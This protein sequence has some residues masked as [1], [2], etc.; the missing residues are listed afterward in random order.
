MSKAKKISLSVLFQFVSII[1]TGLVGILVVPLIIELLG[2][3][4]FGVLEIIISLM[5]LNFF[6]ELGMGSTVLRFVPVYEKEGNNALNGFLWSYLYLKTFLASVATIVIFAVGYNFDHIFNIGQT[7]VVLVKSA[8][9]IFAVGILVTNIAT[10]FSN[11]LKGFQRFDFAIIPNLISQ[12]FF[13]GLIYILSFKEINDVDILNI[14]FLMFV[15]RPL[16]SIFIAIFFIKKTNS[17]ISFYPARLQKRF[18]KESF[19]FLKGMSFISLFSQFYNR[20]PKIILGIILNP[21]SVACWGIAERLRSP[22]EQI[23]SSLIRPLIPMASSMNLDDDFQKVAELIIKITKVHFLLIAGIGSFAVLYVDTFIDIWIGKDYFE[24]ANIV[25]IWFIS[26]ILPNSSVL[27]M[28]YYAK[29][30]TKLSQNVSVFISFFGLTLGY[31]LALKFDV[32]G[33]AFGLVLSS[34]F[35]SIVCFYYLCK[36]FF[37][38]F[39]VIFKKS[40]L[41]SYVVVILS[42][43]VNFLLIHYFNPD[44]LYSFFSLL[45]FG[46]LVYISFIYFSLSYDE[47]KF[48]NNLIKSFNLMKK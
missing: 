34:I 23:N 24:V 33:F 38:D 30:K 19:S 20:A 37:L 45:L 47:K 26:F 31:M 42:M 18:L 40:Y 28:F 35:G 43:I 10:F 17:N 2:N 21:I 15:I 27:M 39:W 9:Y 29:G 36:E 25:K 13:L 41:I 1:V 12:L 8:V 3:E 32:K 11:T 14:A 4:Y 5:F 48:Y 46:L 44:N 22:I 7:D 16:I 6:F